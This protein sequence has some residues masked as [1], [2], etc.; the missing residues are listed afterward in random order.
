MATVLDK[1]NHAAK[2]RGALAVIQAVA[3]TVREAGETP[4]GPVYAALMQHGATLQQYERIVGILE[5]AG[6][7][8]VS[9]GG[10]LLTWIG[11]K[12]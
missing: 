1:V 11:P 2:V 12:K 3:D 5:G 9:G 6:L 10:E 8:K 7:V 4:A